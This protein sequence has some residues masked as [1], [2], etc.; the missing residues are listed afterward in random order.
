[1]NID[2]IAVDRDC[3]A[4]VQDSKNR[5]LRLAKVPVL[6]SGPR[7]TDT[8][9][10]IS[11][12][13]LKPRGHFLTR[14]NR[15]HLYCGMTFFFF[16][17]FPY[18]ARLYS[19]V[20]RVNV[21]PSV[22]QHRAVR[23]PE[24]CSVRICGEPNSHVKGRSIMIAPSCQSIPRQFLTRCFSAGLRIS[25]AFTLSSLLLILLWGY[26]ETASGQ[27]SGRGT[28]QGTVS[29][30]TGAII[31]GGKVKLVEVRTNQENDQS[32]TSAGFYS[33][34]G[35]QPGL[36]SV[37]VT[38]PGFQTYTQENIPLDALQTFGLNVKMKVGGAES[39]IEHQA[40]TR[41]LVWSITW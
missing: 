39:V 8:H 40:V 5:G 12:C 37:T 33:F 29:D 7:D 2:G 15:G 19:P 14:T 16:L 1:M 23:S 22:I 24:R 41:A 25:L 35:L 32:T 18:Q 28:I 27:I 4:G 10:S 26:C 34:G 6:V 31:P 38:A 21:Y 20:C 9:P 11:A 36:Y 3:H 13:Q 30:Q 17:D